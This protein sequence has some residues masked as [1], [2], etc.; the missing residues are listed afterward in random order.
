M[1]R[2]NNYIIE[3]LKISKNMPDEKYSLA[4]QLYCRLLPDDYPLKNKVIDVLNDWLDGNDIK[5]IN[6]DI[7]YT[8]SN[9]D[10]IEKVVQD[11]SFL[12]FSTEYVEGYNK[13]IQILKLDTMM[14]S[15]HR[16]FGLKNDK[17]KIYMDNSKLLFV[18][19]NTSV[20]FVI[21]MN[22]WKKQ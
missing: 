20:K 4:E 18:Y 13:L 8:Y 14:T 7:F 3:K 10:R 5:D 1:K 16:A 9:R 6:E 11:K 2:I 21:Y 22:A 19:G 12:R 15:G 17:V